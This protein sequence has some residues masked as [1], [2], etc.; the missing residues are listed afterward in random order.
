MRPNRFIFTATVAAIAAVALTAP[1]LAN[2]L[3]P[4]TDAPEFTLTDHA[5]NEVSLSDFDGKVR[6]LEWINPDCPFVQRHYKAETMTTLASEY[7]DKDVVWMAINTTHY[8]NEKKN[9]EFAKKHE[10]PYPVLDDSS[11][12]VGKHYHAATTPHMVIIDGNGTVVY[13]G[14]I[15]DDPRGRNGEEATNYVRAALDRLLAGESIDPASTKPYGCS[16]KYAK[17]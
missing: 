7:A 14:A 11:G 5:G 12:T 15:D 6:V 1:T 9:A 10:L 4:G 8:F 3:E 17:R 13:N 16:V 2:E